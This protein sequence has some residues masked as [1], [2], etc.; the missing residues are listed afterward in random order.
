MKKLETTLDLGDGPVVS[1]YCN[2]KSDWLLTGIGVVDN[3][4]YIQKLNNEIQDL[5]S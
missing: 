2:E 4:I 1:K 5:Y 3:Y